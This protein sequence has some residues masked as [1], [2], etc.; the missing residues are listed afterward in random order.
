MNF[1]NKIK[2]FF[3]TVIV[4]LLAGAV[5]LGVFGFN[6][7]PNYK[8]GYELNVKV[9]ANIGTA[10]EV[11]ESATYSYLNSKGVTF[12][13]KDVETLDEGGV[14][15]IR[16]AKDISSKIS[17]TEL[18]TAV[19]SAMQSS[20]IL[21]GIEVTAK[22]YERK[23]YSS[24]STLWVTIALASA[25]VV[26]FIYVALVHKLSSAV[27][28]FAVSILSAMVFAS[29]LAISR[30]SINAYFLPGMFATAVLSA[31]YAL[32]IVTKCEL[33]ASKSVNDKTPYSVI[34]DKSTKSVLIGIIIASV[35]LLAFAVAII[36]LG[37]T[38][39]LGI[40]MAI[41]TVLSAIISLFLSGYLWAILKPYSKKRIIASEPIKEDK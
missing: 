4:I 37:S 30:I 17:L 38:I 10:S 5:M 20:E 16:F 2:V 28:V 3:I 8:D 25:L 15:I 9:D 21:K 33:N 35:S 14:L 39:F 23:D 40:Q 29:V 26:G 6:T 19:E 36:V 7:A 32:S 34:A 11:I 27:A 22:L 1:V 31:V 18:E 12:S 13:D 24:N 41:I